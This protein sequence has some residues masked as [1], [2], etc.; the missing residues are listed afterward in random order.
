M[1][2]RQPDGRCNIVIKDMQAAWPDAQAALSLFCRGS[3][4]FKLVLCTS[5]AMTITSQA[6]YRAITCVPS[7]PRSQRPA[8]KATIL[9]PEGEWTS[10]PGCITSSIFSRWSSL[11]NTPIVR[12]WTPDDSL[13]F[14]HFNVFSPFTV[15]EK[16]LYYIN[17]FTTV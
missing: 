11:I 10:Q 16:L 4:H 8:G 2:L 9:D 15:T 1:L 14:A 3:A 5:P 13:D 6:I 7:F 12:H 17:I